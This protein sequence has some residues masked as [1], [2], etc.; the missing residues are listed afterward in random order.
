MPI[1][2][3]IRLHPNNIR[4][5]G[6]KNIT[7]PSV[8]NNILLQPAITLKTEKITIRCADLP[9]EI[10]LRSGDAYLT[11]EEVI[12]GIYKFLQKPIRK[13]EWEAICRGQPDL[14]RRCQET[15]VHRCLTS[16]HRQQEEAHGRKRV[17][18]LK[19]HLF[20]G[21]NFGPDNTVWMKTMD[22]PESQA[23]PASKVGRK[24]EIMVFNE[25][26][27]PTPDQLVSL[28]E[29]SFLSQMHLPTF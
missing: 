11:A 8:L 25:E 24:S 17:D 19:N 18:L 27:F 22:V 4:L 9:W 6:I 15:F 1:Y 21:L 29:D 2:F 3:D 23:Y 12:D 7:D 10:R 5:S 13:D 16:R 20:A 14:A 26:D 28:S